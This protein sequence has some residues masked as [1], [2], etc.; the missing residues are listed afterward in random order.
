[1]KKIII[2]SFCFFCANILIL[3]AQESIVTT[4]GEAS[5]TGGTASYSYGQVVYTTNIGVSGSNAQ[6][7]QQPYE[8]S[9]VTSVDELKD[10]NFQCNLF[11][12]PTDNYVQLK[13]ENLKIENLIYRLCDANGKEIENKKILNN[14][15][16]I[17]MV[18]LVPSAYFLK[19]YKNKKAIKT[20]KIIKN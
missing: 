20:F 9:V 7:V 4:G 2:F 3:N 12:N 19:I 6:G 10:I 13:I 14:E 15:T 18:S 8:I 17:S 1:M 16:V 11:P 5:G